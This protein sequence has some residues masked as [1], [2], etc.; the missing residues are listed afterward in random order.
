MRLAAFDPR[1]RYL[2]GTLGAFDPRARYLTGLAG[3]RT[4]QRKRR[5]RRM[6][7]GLGDD[8]Y[9]QAIAIDAAASSGMATEQFDVP[10]P[11]SNPPSL[12]TGSGGQSPYSYSG[13]NP[14]GSGPISAS[15]GNI[16]GGLPNAGPGYASSMP[17]PGSFPVTGA[18]VP[19]G[20][21]LVPVPGG[22]PGAYMY[23]GSAIPGTT[24]GISNT[25]LM[26]GAG[27]I[28]LLAF[29]GGR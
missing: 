9:A 11:S 7:M 12:I 2:T 14:M 4:T 24:F 3:S 5:V 25:T 21:P 8:P 22:A 17:L 28:A 19:A 15:G 27:L 20:T 23:A 26:I 18:P 1:A 10:L 29:M 13:T 6:L 16:Y